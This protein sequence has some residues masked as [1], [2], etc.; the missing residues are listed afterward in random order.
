MTEPIS[1]CLPVDFGMHARGAA[2]RGAG[3][4]FAVAH[5]HQVARGERAAVLLIGR[6]EEAVAVQARGKRALGADEEALPVG[7]LHELGEQRPQFALAG[8][9]IGV[10][11]AVELGRGARCQRDLLVGEVAD[12]TQLPRLDDSLAG[13]L[14]RLEAMERLLQRG[15]AGHRAVILQEHAIE[16]LAKNSG[17]VAAQRFTAGQ[18]V[19]REP[20]LA[21]DVPRLVK[22]PRVGHL[23]HQ[24]EGHQRHRMRMHDAANVRTRAVDFLMERQ[25]A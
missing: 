12:L 11:E 5:Q 17:H 8:G 9:R 4:A 16:K 6:H 7:A 19:G 2:G 25:F 18:F 21:A 15:A 24:A 22:Q 10:G 23:V 1:G 13:E 14:Q 20:R 3:F